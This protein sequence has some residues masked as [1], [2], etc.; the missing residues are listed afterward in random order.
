MNRFFLWINSDGEKELITAPL[1]GTILPGITRDSVL[2]L[3]RE[4]NEFLVSERPYTIKDFICACNEGR[5]LESFGS[6]TAAIIS[7]VK[8]IGY[9]DVDYEIPLDVENPGNE[10]GPLALRLKEN[11]LDIQYGRVSHEWSQIV[12]ENIYKEV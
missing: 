1:D 2:K 9:Q 3:C 6:G 5:I 11:I 4:W 10:C 12:P 8:R 7:P